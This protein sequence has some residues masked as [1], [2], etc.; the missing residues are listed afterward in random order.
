L[1]LEICASAYIFLTAEIL[2]DKG[3]DI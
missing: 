2:F 1:R 3:R